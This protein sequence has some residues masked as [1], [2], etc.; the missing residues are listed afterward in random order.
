MATNNPFRIENVTQGKTIKN[1]GFDLVYLSVQEANRMTV[2]VETDDDFA[3]DDEIEF[4]QNSTGYFRGNVENITSDEE[5]NWEITVIGADGGIRKERVNRTFSG[6]IGIEQAVKNAVEDNTGFTVQINFTSGQT[7]DDKTYDDPLGTLFQDL[8]DNTRV[9][10]R[11]DTFNKTI[12]LEEEGGLDNSRT[13]NTTGSNANF[14]I[15]DYEEDGSN[16]IDTLKIKGNPKSKEITGESFS[17]SS[18]QT[19]I[20]LSK[21]SDQVETIDEVRVNGSKQIK[22]FSVEESADFRVQLADDGLPTNQLTF[23][24]SFSGSESVEVDYTFVKEPSAVVTVSDADGEGYAKKKI[25][26]VTSKEEAQKAGERI[27]SK[28]KKTE[29]AI[30]GNYVNDADRKL[31]LDVKAGEEVT[32][33]AEE[34]GV[35]G[36]TINIVKVTHSFPGGTTMELG[37][38]ENYSLQREKDQERR[39]G[40]EEDDT[41]SSIADQFKEKGLRESSQYTMP[42]G[43]QIENANQSA[44]Q[45]FVVYVPN[46]KFLRYAEVDLVRSPLKFD[47]TDVSVSGEANTN[48]QTD[49]IAKRYD[50]FGGDNHPHDVAGLTTPSA[51]GDAAN[52]N[53][54][55]K[56]FSGTGTF[57]EDVQIPFVDGEGGFAIIYCQTQMDASESNFGG[58][59]VKIE[60]TTTG[61]VLYDDGSLTPSYQ[62]G[63]TRMHMVA[64]ARGS[65]DLESDNIRFTFETSDDRRWRYGIGVMCFGEHSHNISTVQD[66]AKGNDTGGDNDYET[67]DANEGDLQ[68]LDADGSTTDL[69]SKVDSGSTDTASGS[70]PGIVDVNIDVSNSSGTT[71]TNTVTLGQGEDNFGSKINLSDLEKGFNRIEVYPTT[72]STIRLG[73]LVRL[74]LTDR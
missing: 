65:T 49:N 59:Q 39:Q 46:K 50:S 22:S 74:G 21:P 26:S 52:S 56:T 63:D 1:F 47:K 44:K 45:S 30:T 8:I 33:N 57:T 54:L 70:E 66:R 32:L 34:K 7:F 11:V 55:N 42:H 62:P 51:A 10:I 24:E 68:N 19:V 16:V 23:N 71:T 69:S 53:P 73:T 60:N 14:K 36:R 25:P 6:G 61:D 28:L 64:Q 37:R 5:N 43:W 12:F 17:P 40:S 2:M 38:P 72:S 15:T 27:I 20:T 31:D 18:G 3:F 9:Q 13:L 48:S 35:S 58:L 29:L 67:N 4:Y 41:F